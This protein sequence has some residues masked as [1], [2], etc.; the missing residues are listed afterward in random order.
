MDDVDKKVLRCRRTNRALVTDLGRH[1]DN[2]PFQW[3]NKVKILSAL[4]ISG[5]E[6][7]TVKT[8]CYSVGTPNI[9]TWYLIQ[10]CYYFMV[11]LSQ[12][13]QMLG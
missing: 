12:S 1:V 3:F 6:A 5:E 7:T 8:R 9:M 4:R 2:V 10:Y 11:F 13:K